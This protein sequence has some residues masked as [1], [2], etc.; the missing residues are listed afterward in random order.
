MS[1]K[2]LHCCFCCASETDGTGVVHDNVNASKGLH[3]LCNCLGHL[4][5][6]ANVHYTRQAL[7]SGSLNYTRYKCAQLSSSNG[8]S[9]ASPW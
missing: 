6:K 8:T 3:S 4:V 5:L 9:L 2:L 1:H 7:P